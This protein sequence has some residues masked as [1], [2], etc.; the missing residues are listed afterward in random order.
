LCN[1][2][3]NL[4]CVPQPKRYIKTTTLSTVPILSTY[5]QQHRPQ[6]SAPMTEQRSNTAQP[7]TNAFQ[8]NN[9]LTSPLPNRSCRP[10]VPLPSLLVVA[11]H[12][13][14][15]LRNCVLYLIRLC[16]IRPTE[17]TI[18]T[19]STYDHDA[20]ETRIRDR[21]IQDKMILKRLVECRQ[22]RK[23]SKM[24]PRVALD[25]SRSDYQHQTGC[26]ILPVYLRMKREATHTKP[27]RHRLFAVTRAMPT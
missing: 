10:S 9:A 21:Y 1:S 8:I 14:C 5:V 11:D 18:D 16:Q 6:K 17:G 22:S 19:A 26:R 27:L 12:G 23:I 7:T 13:A 3:R 24:L 15:C 2:K 4:Q 20:K 25:S